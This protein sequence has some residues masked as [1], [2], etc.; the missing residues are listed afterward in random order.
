MQQLIK[1][2]II[3]VLFLI[4]TTTIA[5]LDK[6]KLI[7]G[8]VVDQM[9]AD[10]L[11]RFANH[12]GDDGLKL[13][14]KEGTNFQNCHYNYVPTFTGPGHASIYTGTTPA[15]HGIVANAWWSREEGKRVNC[16]ED[17][18]SKPVGSSP[19]SKGNYSPI[20]LKANTITDQIKL[21]D[22]RT[23]VFSISIKNRGAIL[24]GGHAADGVY[25]YDYAN[26]GFM[27]SSFYANKLPD[28]VVEYNKARNASTFLPEKW[29]T[30]KPI[31]TYLE[32]RADNYAFE[33]SITNEEP[34]FPYNLKKAVKDGKS[35]TELF[36]ETPFANTLLTDFARKILEM[37]KLGADEVTDFLAISYSS[38]DIIG[39]S[40]GPYSKEMQDVMIRLDR[41]LAK[42]IKS[43]D[44]RVGRDN[45]VLFLTADHAV[46]PIP[47]YLI[48]HKMAAGYFF[49]KPFEDALRSAVAKQF[50]EG[51]IDDVYNNSI[52]LNKQT[53]EQGGWEYVKVVS[54]VKEFLSN[55][56]HIKQVYSGRELQE[57][58]Y[59]HDWSVKIAMGYHPEESGDVLFTLEPG[60]LPVK[61]DNLK[62]KQ[63]T[64]HGSAFSYDTQ[65]P[66]LFFG[67]GVAAQN[68]FREVEITSITPTLSLL[69]GLTKPSGS[70]GKVLQEV[71]R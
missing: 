22:S 57:K 14:L 6:P 18:H 30:L 66:L 27:T 46:E 41:D 40:Y 5:Q 69:L 1:Q 64:S 50:G 71:L 23:K 33:A 38:P 52:Y 37:E 47:Q 51:L 44:D 2:A 3:A 62:S 16:V 32:S 26:G 61:E 63:G 49:W 34:V 29:E 4:S 59:L 45:Y 39:H 43:L 7:V 58:G 15:N 21:M 12:Y 20:R 35:L 53:I 65:V 55:Y 13:L 36:T 67:K 10:Y 42:L 19:D 8:I 17:K 60:Y 9:R 25:W 48:D 24:P 56:P 54:F 70:T 31:E 28:W 68:V 11:Y